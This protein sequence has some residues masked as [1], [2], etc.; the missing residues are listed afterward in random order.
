MEAKEAIDGVFIVKFIK[1][2]FPQGKQTKIKGYAFGWEFPF[3]GDLLQFGVLKIMGEKDTVLLNISLLN[4]RGA[5][6]MY[7][8]PA[9]KNA[10]QAET[11]F[12]IMEL[13]KG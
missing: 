2:E 11:L 10:D 6:Q 4:K 5:M 9:P 1:R 7:F 12:S 13:N 3:N 8:S